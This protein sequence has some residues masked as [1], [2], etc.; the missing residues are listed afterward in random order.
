MIH[1]DREDFVI[2]QRGAKAISSPSETHD[3][4]VFESDC[5]MAKVTTTAHIL[6]KGGGNK[7]FPDWVC[8]CRDRQT[9]DTIMIF[10]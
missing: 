5:I 3:L 1:F 6:W 9:S 2:G 8:V 10:F 7:F 4:S